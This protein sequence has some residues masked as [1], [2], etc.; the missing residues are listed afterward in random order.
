MVVGVY[1]AVHRVGLDVERVEFHRVG[2][3]V[4]RVL[5]RVVDHQ[6]A[7]RCEAVA[8]CLVVEEVVAVQLVLVHRVDVYHVAESLVLLRLVVVEERVAGDGFLTVYDGRATIQ[9]RHVCLAVGVGIGGVDDGSLR[10]DGRRTRNVCD[11]CACVVVERVGVDEV[12]SAAH[13]HAI[14]E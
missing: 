1:F 7:L 13:L 2:V 14:E 10:C 3:H 12:L 5:L 6:C 9:L 8:R 4:Q 11:T